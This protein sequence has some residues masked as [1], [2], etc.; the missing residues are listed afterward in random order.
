[1]KKLIDLQFGKDDYF[2]SLY[3]RSQSQKT[4]NDK[5]ELYKKFKTED[6]FLEKIKSIKR[7]IYKVVINVDQQDNIINAKS[8]IAKY[9]LNHIL[10]L[11]NEYNY[12][13]EIDLE[14]YT[15]NTSINN[16][17]GSSKGYVG[18]EQGG[19]L[20]EH[21]I[22]YPITLI[23]FKNFNKAHYIV[24]NYIKKTWKALAM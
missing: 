19:I 14:D 8:N 15:D 16:L 7:F 1:M 5:N 2:R 12:E 4:R 17:I 9:C 22:K 6:E 13:L 10:T 20:S 18:Y 24:Q 3:Q 11:T 21:I 23:F